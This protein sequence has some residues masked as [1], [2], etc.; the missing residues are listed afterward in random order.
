MSTVR[1]SQPAS[2]QA[3]KQAKQAIPVAT[4]KRSAVDDGPG[5][6]ESLIQSPAS[7]AMAIQPAGRTQAAKLERLVLAP[8]LALAGRCGIFIANVYS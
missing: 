2:K 1:D 6:A 5:P 3:S 4:E 7:I 8:A